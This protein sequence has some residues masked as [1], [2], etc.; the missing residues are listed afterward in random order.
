MQI[1]QFVIRAIRND[2]MISQFKLNIKDK[3]VVGNSRQAGGNS[4]ERTMVIDILLRAKTELE[5]SACPRSLRS[6]GK[7]RSDRLLGISRALAGL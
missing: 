3:K 1:I 2:T 7:G 6:R 5:P 4:H